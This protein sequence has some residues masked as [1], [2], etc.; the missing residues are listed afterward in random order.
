MKWI[1][2][3]VLT[4]LSSDGYNAIEVTMKDNK[5][6]HFV[7]KRDCLNYARNNFISLSVFA[8]LQFKEQKEI[9]NIYC[10]PQIPNPSI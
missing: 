7:T 4:T 2:V 5:P 6:L 8:L 10:V 3:V 1:I 9:E